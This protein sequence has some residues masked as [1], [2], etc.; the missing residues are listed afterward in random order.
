MSYVLS[1]KRQFT[2]SLE[3]KHPKEVTEVSKKEKKKDGGDE[4][5]K[6]KKKA[7][8]KSSDEEIS[9]EERPKKKYKKQRS[10]S[11]SYSEDEED[12]QIVK[13]KKKG[14]L[15]E[16][17]LKQKKQRRASSSVSPIREQ[18]SKEYSSLESDISY[19]SEDERKKKK[20]RV[21]NK[22]DF[23]EMEDFKMYDEKQQRR[24]FDQRQGFD[25]RRRDEFMHNR[26][27]RN[28]T[29]TRDE[30]FNDRPDDRRR[31]NQ[32]GPRGADYDLGD[33]RPNQY[34]DRNRRMDQRGC[35]DRGNRGRINNRFDNRDNRDQDYFRDAR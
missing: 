18:Y 30:S 22:D 27:G 4:V 11:W 14:K 19:E 20:K 25:D 21:K 3:T 17:K 35:E 6:K 26:K 23:Q 12:E 34:E 15:F 9:E 24:H 29:Y 16:A 32:F 5:S 28:D 31:M 33:W 7:K 8:P 1:P 2:L 10:P 13:S